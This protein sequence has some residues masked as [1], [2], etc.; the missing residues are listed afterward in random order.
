VI[1]SS[2]YEGGP[3]LAL[4]G[5]LPSSKLINDL[6]SSH[7]P[8]I[9]ADGAA[10]KLRDR[11]IR[12]DI[13]IGDLDTLRDERHD[14]FFAEATIIADPGQDEY[15]SGKALAWIIG[16]GYEQ[17]MVIGAEGGMIDHVLNNF[18]LLARFSDRLRIAVRQ[19]D[20]VGYIVRDELQLSTEPGDRISLIPLPKARVTTEGLQ[21]N[22]NNEILE[23]RSREGG[24]N[25]AVEN[26][27]VVQVVGTIALFS[28]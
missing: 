17:V 28:Y 2:A 20:S 4:D 22:L 5:D 21:W 3:L 1:T 23:I 13:I 27:V 12:P 7:T 9:A 24:S 16:K 26:R 18:S 8:L 10:L 25:R 15:D 11:D 14:P 19:E 6:Y